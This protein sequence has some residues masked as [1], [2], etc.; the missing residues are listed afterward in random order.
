MKPAPPVM[1]MFLQSGSGSNLVDPVSTGAVFQ[2]PV[3]RK[4]RVAGGT[5]SPSSGRWRFAGVGCGDE[6]RLL[7]LPCAI[8]WWWRGEGEGKGTRCLE[9]KIPV[10]PHVRSRAE[11]LY[12][13]PGNERAPWS[14]ESVAARGGKEA[15]SA[16]QGAGCKE[17]VEGGGR[18]G[19]K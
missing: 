10:E 6:G 11:A 9:R 4:W 16:T 17:A 14:G 15:G 7:L 19:G 13:V 3:S 8:A 5:L 1:R 2:I 12:Q 18:E